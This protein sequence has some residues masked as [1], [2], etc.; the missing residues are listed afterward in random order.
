[1]RT[2][3]HLPEGLGPNTVVPVIN[4]WLTSTITVNGSTTV[5]AA[6]TTGEYNC[7][8]VSGISLKSPNTETCVSAGTACIPL[9]GML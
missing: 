4:V 3:F 7:M 2:Y 8:T 9:G 5:L 6:R 1:M